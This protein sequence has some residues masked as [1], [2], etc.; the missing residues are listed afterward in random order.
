MVVG[1]SDGQVKMGDSV[2]DMEA[3]TVWSIREALLKAY[4]EAGIELDV[5]PSILGLVDAGDLAKDTPWDAMR[6]GD[7]LSQMS[8]GT[9]EEIL[10]ELIKERE[11]GRSVKD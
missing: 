4:E 9:I 8:N 6:Y 2:K 7:A 3:I 5:N 1:L 11:N 10:E